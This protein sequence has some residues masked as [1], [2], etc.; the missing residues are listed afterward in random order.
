MRKFSS[1]LTA[2]LCA[3]ALTAHSKVFYVAPTGNNTDSGTITKPFLTLQRAQDAVSPGDTVWV[4][5]GTYMMQN[6]QIAAY[7][8]PY[9]YITR[10]SKSGSAT[11]GRINYWAYPGEQPVFNY[12]NVDPNVSTPGAPF[13]AP[14]RLSAIEVT[15]SYIHLRGLEIM[16]VRVPLV[17]NNV[18]T[19]SICVSQSG[20][21]GNNIYEQLSMHDGQAIGFFLTRGGNTLVLNCDAYRN[22]DNVNISNTTGTRGGGNIDGFGSHPNSANYTGIVFR[23]CRA[24]LNSDDGYDCISANAATTFDN[25]WAFYNGYAEGSSG[26]VSRGDG[27]GFKAGGYGTSASP[28][29]PAVIPRNIVRSCLAVQNKASGFY[30]NHHLGGNDWLNNTAYMNATNYNMLNRRA[31]YLA[32]VPGYGHVLRNNVSLAPRATSGTS[33]I[34]D[35]DPAQCIID[36]NTFLNPSVTVSAAD[37]KS[38]DKALLVVTRLPNGDLPEVDLLRLATGSDLIDAGI[39]V[40]LPYRGSAPDL[41]YREY[42]PALPTVKAKDITVAV[43]A[44]GQLV[45][46]PQMVDDGSISYDGTLTLSLSQ[47][48]FDCSAIGTPV[49][50]T[51]TGTDAGGYSASATALVTVTDETP[52]SLTAPAN[53]FSCYS[54]GS[55][56]VPALV[57]ADNCGVAS[58]SYAI[59]GATVRSGSGADA[60]GSFNVG[61]STIAWT[62]TDLHNNQTTGST[63]VTVNEPLLVSIPDVYAVSQTLDAKNTLYIGYGPT[64]LLLNA[65]SA[66]GTAPYTYAWSTGQS[67]AAISVTAAGTYTVTVTDAKG[68][69]EVASLTINVVDVTCGNNNNKVLVCHNGNAICVAAAAVQTHLNHGDQ[70]GACATP[71]K[72]LAQGSQTHAA[73]ESARVVL[74]PNPVA[75]QLTIGLPIGSE[76]ASVK[77]YSAAGKLVLA[78]RLSAKNSVVSLEGLPAG[79]YYAQVLQGTQLTTERIVKE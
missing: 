48:A 28:G 2:V 42:I 46:T 63:T 24:W 31:D 67:T 66:G 72:T 61:V 60:S 77:L 36:H 58:I 4:R 17:P 53:Q 56:T 55:Y 41:G 11:A 9:A 71:T 40:G 78:Q 65:E 14:Y 10:L 12:A 52:P 20:A 51:L 79:L 39:D 75:N 45:I 29:A 23:G 49:T 32:D 54:G 5:G 76:S 50:V 38:L 73:G 35:Y 27:N 33:H 64:S 44:N 57:A 43:D 68:C 26:F 8:S 25:C 18:N 16:G 21:G 47:S 74:Y 13:T 34:T 62:V 22:N 70:L 7:A 3:S 30:A 69:T 15:G 37:F 6:S 19:Q 1:L 59:T